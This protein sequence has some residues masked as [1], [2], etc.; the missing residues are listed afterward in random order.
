[1]KVN[2]YRYPSTAAE[3]RA[4][5]AA[6]EQGVMVRAKRNPTHI[7]DAMCD[8]GVYTERNWKSFRNNQW[9]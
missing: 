4:Y 9:R 1:M 2:G 5:S 6:V 8:I 3:K 7:A